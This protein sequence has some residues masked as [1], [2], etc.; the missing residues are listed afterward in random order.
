MLTVTY[1]WLLLGL[2]GLALPI[3]AHLIYSQQSQ[4]VRFSSIRLIV[5]TRTPQAHRKGITDALLLLLRLLI[6]ICVTLSIAGLEWIPANSTYFQR[7][8]VILLDMS[9]SMSTSDKQERAKSLVADLIED[10][11][12][13]AGLV[14]YGQHA[15]TLSALTPDKQSLLK[16]LNDATPTLEEGNPQKAI[17]AVVKLYSTGAPEKHLLIVSDFQSSD[18][19]QVS[20]DLR[21]HSI[22]FSLHEVSGDPVGDPIENQTILS[23]ETSELS[24]QS[25]R[26]SASLINYSPADQQRTIELSVAGKQIEQVTQLLSGQVKQ[27]FFEVPKS[28]SGKAIVRIAEDDGYTQDNTLFF[29]LTQPLPTR[30][31]IVTPA[32]APQQSLNEAKFLRAALLSRSDYEWQRFEVVDS[33][34]L[35]SGILHTDY[36]DLLMIAGLASDIPSDIGAELR[37]FI[38]S[39]GVVVATTGKGMAETLRQLNHFHLLSAQFMGTGSKTRLDMSPFRI[40]A[41]EPDSPLQSIFSGSA[42]NDLMLTRIYRFSKIKLLEPARVIARVDG[43]Y[44]LIVDKP[45]GNGRLIFSAMRMDS[46]WSDLPLRPSFVPLIKEL[47]LPYIDISEHPSLTVNEPLISDDLQFSSA[48]P[49]LYV[50]QGERLSVNVSRRE[51]IPETLTSSAVA[52]ILGGSSPWESGRHA[53]PAD[54]GGHSQLSHP[55]WQWFMLAA[56]LS[57]LLESIIA[58]YGPTSTASYRTALNAEPVSNVEPILDKKPNVEVEI[59]P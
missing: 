40:S 36:I 15:S 31:G 54:N 12:G 55:L 51:S 59:V 28:L 38:Q 50:D 35:Q 2:L 27:L 13:I 45:I 29:W 17:Q 43:D 56:V 19:Q 9:A 32:S 58:R 33:L 46:N 49:G 10:E 4:H 25:L 5:P 3:A 52:E 1:P 6:V 11:N 53:T 16:A 48:Q 37:L 22:S 57:L 47:V 39:G 14:T 21:D 26:V 24:N 23:V 20:Y 34:N 41:L 18:W 42:S 7:E 44:P 8:T 30:V